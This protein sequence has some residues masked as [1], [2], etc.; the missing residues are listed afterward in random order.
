MIIP[1]DYLPFMALFE[2]L[3]FHYDPHGKDTIVVFDEERQIKKDVKMKKGPIIQ[4]HNRVT[5]PKSLG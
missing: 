4:K 1:I 3:Q 2:H 5:C